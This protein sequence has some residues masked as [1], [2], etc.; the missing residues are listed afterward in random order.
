[1]LIVLAPDEPGDEQAEDLGRP[2]ADL[3]ELLVAVHPF[4]GISFKLADMRTQ[5]EAA[6]LMLYRAA[7]L[8]DQGRDI[9]LAAAMAKLYASEAA[10]FCVN[11]AVQ[12][13]GGYGLLKNNPV[14]RLYRDQKFLEIGEGTS[15]ILRLLIARLIGCEEAGR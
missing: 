12:V 4:Q 11:E 10:H 14:E 7:W 13:F 3:Q 5:I 8:C 2:F 15:E 1:M 9:R 6:R